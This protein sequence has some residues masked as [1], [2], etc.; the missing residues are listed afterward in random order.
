[1]GT[2]VSDCKENMDRRTIRCHPSKAREGCVAQ[3]RMSHRLLEGLGAPDNTRSICCRWRAIWRCPGLAAA[4]G[5]LTLTIVSLSSDFFLPSHGGNVSHAM[6]GHKAYVGHRKHMNP[7]KH[8]MLP[9][10]EAATI[11]DIEFSSFVRN[12]HQFSLGQ[13]ELRTNKRNQDVIAYPVPECMCMCK[14]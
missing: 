6:K 5:R 7:N 11:N 14:H 2:C 13:P 1:M 10:F 12:L 8:V 4:H 9:F 3:N